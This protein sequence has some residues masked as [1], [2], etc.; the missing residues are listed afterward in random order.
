MKR[1]KDGRFSV[2][3]FAF[4][5][6]IF[7]SNSFAQDS[8]CEGASAETDGDLMCANE[9]VELANVYKVKQ[10]QGRVLIN[11]AEYPL[12]GVI[13]IYVVSKLDAKS[14]PSDLVKQLTPFKRF[15]TNERG[16]FCLTDIA[17]GNYVLKVGTSEGG[18]NCTWLKVKVTKSGSEK[19]IKIDLTPGT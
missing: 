9:R 8:K 11:R 4:L 19:P 18:F 12:L 3:T 7:I 6:L 14:L 1:R 2:I 13:D 10:M 15:K 16:E 5:L 17:E